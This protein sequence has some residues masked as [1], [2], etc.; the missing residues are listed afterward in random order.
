MTREE[1]S[2]GKN[3][4]ATD[5]DLPAEFFDTPHSNQLTRAKDRIRLIAASMGMALD[6]EQIDIFAILLVGLETDGR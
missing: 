4:E 5:S 6:A 3:F 2:K 1:M